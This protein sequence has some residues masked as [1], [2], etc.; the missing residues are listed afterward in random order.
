M[1]MLPEEMRT[2]LNMLELD[3]LQEYAIKGKEE[4][5]EKALERDGRNILPG[6]LISVKSSK[7]RVE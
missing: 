4:D 6:S 2:K 7:E 3:F 5:L 1:N